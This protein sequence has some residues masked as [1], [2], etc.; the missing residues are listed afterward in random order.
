VKIDLYVHVVQDSTLGPLL[1]RIDTKLDTILMKEAEQ[2]AIGDDILAKITA[3][4]T[5]IGSIKEYIAGLAGNTI[6]QDV[7][8]A[9]LQHLDENT[10]ALSTAIPANVPPTP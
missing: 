3:Q 10:A 2:M 6:P 8:D 9:I 7:A 1:A 4:T 5:L